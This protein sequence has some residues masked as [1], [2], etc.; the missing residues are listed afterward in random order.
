MP[1]PLR[2]RLRRWV[3]D[4]LSQ[5]RSAPDYD[6]PV[7]D[8]GLF[9]PETA[10]WKIHADFPS[11]MAGGLAS[12]MLQA[13]HPL[14]LA[15][16]WDHSDFS[17][18]VLGRLRR[19][20][21]FVARTTYAPHAVA[22]QAIERV[23]TV[24][25]RIHG[26]AADGRAYS[27][28][29]PH[30]LTWVHCAEAWCFLRG[31]QTYCQASVPAAAQ[32]R[33]LSETARVAESLGARDV[34]T[35]LAELERYFV[36]IRPELVC[37]A[38]TVEVLAVLE[39]IRLPIPMA[40]LGRGVFLGAGAAL[41]PS[42]TRALMQRGPLAR[43]G[44]QA[45]MQALRLLAPNLRSAMAEGGLAWRACARVGTDYEALFNWPPEDA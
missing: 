35:S 5:D 23:R 27:A 22:E 18:D 29:D 24:H 8:P 6:R 45:A 2:A 41:L 31:Y 32:N 14:A 4:V 37:D 38:R 20:I 26:H 44:D 15:A 42:W 11:M 1:A 13:L 25:G 21:A 34:P 19:T 3:I 10:T 39:T 28:N 12:L 43:S 9:G 36:A 17:T 40:G 7:G 30:L 33:Y 16:V